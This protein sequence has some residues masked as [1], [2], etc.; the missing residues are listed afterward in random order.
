MSNVC[1]N[2]HLKLDKL[3]FMDGGSVTL[4]HSISCFTQVI[5][6]YFLFLRAIGFFFRS[7]GVSPQLHFSLK[8]EAKSFTEDNSHTSENKEQAFCWED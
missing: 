4:F 7:T 6:D 5:V 1:P 8:K 3:S 2:L